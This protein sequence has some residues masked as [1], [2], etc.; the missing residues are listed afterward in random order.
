MGSV[1][2]TAAWYGAMYLLGA[3]AGVQM[4]L[5]EWALDMSMVMDVHLG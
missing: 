5:I 3:L 2:C 1:I 4:G